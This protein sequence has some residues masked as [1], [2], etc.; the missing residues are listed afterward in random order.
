MKV[1]EKTC[2]Q[3][4]RKFTSFHRYAIYCSRSCSSAS[5][6]KKPLVGKTLLKEGVCP[7]CE[8]SFQKRTRNQIYCSERCKRLEDSRK[9]GRQ[10]LK[11]PAFIGWR[12]HDCG[13]PS[14]T[15][16]CSACQWKF[17]QEHKECFV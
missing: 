15:Y 11:D 16:R 10:S 6:R 17:N 4:G 2:P 5:R 7:V 9:Q 13:K 12:C 3:C 8:K 1:F 14:D